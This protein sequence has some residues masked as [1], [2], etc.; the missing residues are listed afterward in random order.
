MDFDMQY[1][2]ESMHHP[3]WK[4]RFVEAFSPLYLDFVKYC[5]KNNTALSFGLKNLFN[6]MIKILQKRLIEENHIKTTFPTDVVVEGQKRG[7]IEN[8]ELCF[9]IIKYLNNFLG[10]KKR[11]SDFKNEYLE[12]LDRF[13]RKF[14]M[15]VETAGD[16]SEQVKEKPLE[17]KLFG[18]EEEYYEILLNELKKIKTIK[19]VRIFGSRAHGTHRKF[20][21]IDLI[22]EGNYTEKGFERIKK[23]LSSL[24]IPYFID[25]YDVHYRLKPFIFRNTMRSALF[26]KRSDYFKDDFVSFLDMQ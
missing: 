24:E 19:F 17:E 15:D 4:T 20:S 22:F 26:Y 13:Y 7:Y 14:S 9:E 23:K 11:S 21:D 3:A 6:R 1:I 16:I 12:V 8:K 25:I 2:E 10:D 5:P 18:L